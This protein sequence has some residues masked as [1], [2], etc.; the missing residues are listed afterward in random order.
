MANPQQPEIRL[1]EESPINEQ[2]AR[3]AGPADAPSESLIAPASGWRPGVGPQPA[4]RG[5]A[6]R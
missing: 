6:T 1:S 5:A 2:H 4:N 3:D